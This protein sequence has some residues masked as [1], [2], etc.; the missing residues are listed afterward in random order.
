M[1]KVKTK[2][3][4]QKKG[5]DEAKKICRKRGKCEICGKTYCKIEAH[6]LLTVG[7][8]RNMSNHLDN[9]IALCVHCHLFGRISFH[10]SGTDLMKKKFDKKFPGRITALRKI[11][12]KRKNIDYK[13]E[14]E[15]LKELYN[16]LY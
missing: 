3:W 5:C 6:H 8:H 14:W 15:D 7:A 1:T 13:K 10:G 12:L 11:A 2:T 4:Y 16:T 9:L